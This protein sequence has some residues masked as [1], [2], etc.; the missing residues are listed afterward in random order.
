L[1]EIGEKWDRNRVDPIYRKSQ[2][3][4]GLRGIE[5]YCELKTHVLSIE[6]LSRIC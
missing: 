1:R 6:E 5:K 4:N 3:L 2:F